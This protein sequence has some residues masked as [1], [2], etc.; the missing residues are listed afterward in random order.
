VTTPAGRGE[1]PAVRGRHRPPGSQGRHRLHIRS[2]LQ[3]RNARAR[4]GGGWTAAPQKTRHCRRR[5]GMDTDRTEGGGPAPAPGWCPGFRFVIPT[6]GRPRPSGTRV[7]RRAH[8]DGPRRSRSSWW[9]TR[10]DP[11]CHHPWTDM[12]GRIRVFHTG[13]D[14]RQCRP[15]AAG[16]AEARGEIVAFLDDDDVWGSPEGWKRQPQARGGPGHGRSA[17]HWSAAV[18]P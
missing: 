18:W 13:G 17:I 4:K 16:V 15:H 12:S 6:A 8:S 1:P 7:A 3:H 5:Y 2:S 10:P 11:A 9:W 14:R